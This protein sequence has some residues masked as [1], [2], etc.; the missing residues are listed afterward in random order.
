[1]QEALCE[2]V[3][4]GASKV[5]PYEGF[6]FLCGGPTDIK[7]AQPI[8]I[9]DA[10]YRE[11]AKDD[12]IEHRIRVA[13]HYKDWSHDSIYRD[14]V[15]FERHLAELSSVIVLALESPG[16]IAELGLFSVIEEYQSKLLVVIEASHYTS[17]SFIK[18]GPVD[19]LEKAHGNQAECHR[20]LAPSGRHTVF[21]P[22]AAEDLQP[23]LA[24]AILRRA[25]KATPER[26]FQAELWF[27]KTLLLCDLINLYS[28]LTL[29]EIHS[30]FEGFKCKVSEGEIKQILYILEKVGLIAMEPKGTQRF[31]VG[32]EPKQYLKFHLV[33]S[34]FDISRF[35][36]NL[37]AEYAA[38]D[39]KRFKAIQEV[40]RRNAPSE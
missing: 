24:E 8:S 27:D 4:L 1:M 30:Q 6:I 5:R 25:S 39:K 2:K 26:N 15:L 38:S 22:G 7:S 23:E 21:D 17:T 29:R 31:Y 3:D 35:R 37:L 14:L 10:I 11:L 33:D 12:V 34:S 36:A 28:A 18:M 32:V 19:Y 13:E 9:R 16:S 20:W 40:R